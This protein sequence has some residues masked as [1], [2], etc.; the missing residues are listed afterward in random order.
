MVLLSSFASGHPASLTLAAAW[1]FYY[2]SYTN[3][4]GWA[5]SLDA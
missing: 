2:F 4:P 1:G 5:L 3:G